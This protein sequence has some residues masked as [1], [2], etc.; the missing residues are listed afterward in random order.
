[1][2]TLV[3]ALS[4]ATACNRRLPITRLPGAYAEHV[5]AAGTW[6]LRGALPP[7][8]GRHAR[9][10]GHRK[11]PLGFLLGPLDAAE[12]LLVSL[13]AGEQGC[14]VQNENNL[15]LMVGLVCHGRGLHIVLIVQNRGFKIHIL[16]KI[17]PGY[18][19]AFGLVITWL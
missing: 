11:V 8:V 12:S 7:L 5:P 2:V 10:Q 3:R 15:G 14:L 4:P 13:G 6:T 1:M 18:D 19:S 16:K 17:S 9:R